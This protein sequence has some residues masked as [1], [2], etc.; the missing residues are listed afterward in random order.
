[1]PSP[2]ELYERYMESEEAWAEENQYLEELSDEAKEQR[3]Q[4]KAREIE[5]AWASRYENQA[6]DTE[7]K[8]RGRR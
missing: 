4:S 7:W 8:E 5:R 3:R 1:M 6:P 2:F